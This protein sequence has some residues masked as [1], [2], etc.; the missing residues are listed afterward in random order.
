MEEE[1]R[2]SAKNVASNIPQIIV[3]LH[4]NGQLLQ[5]MWPH[6]LHILAKLTAKIGAPKKGEKPPLFQ[7]MLEMQKAFGQMK[8]L[9]AA[10][11]L[12]A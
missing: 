9:M 6:R 10:D 11:V 4:L 2:G 1:N 5:G 3:S 8:T 12:C 7:W